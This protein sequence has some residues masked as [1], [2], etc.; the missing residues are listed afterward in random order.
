MKILITGG[1]GYIG[2]H[3][4]KSI[5]H[6]IPG[7]A[8]HIADNL[9]HGHLFLAKYGDEFTDI[10]IT[11][12]AKLSEYVGKLSPDI[13]VHAAALTSVAESQHRPADYYD[14][15]TLGTHNLA[16]ACAAS[17]SVRGFILLS[18][19]AASNPVSV[20]GKTKLLA[21]AIVDSVCGRHRI[22]HTSFRLYNACGAW[23][24]I[25]EA[26]HPETHLIPL[27]I[28]AAVTGE[29]LPIYGKGLSTPDGT[30][31]R[32]YIDVRDIGSACVQA[33]RR[34]NSGDGLA[35]VYDLG[36]GVGR[37][38]LDIIKLVER[39]VGNPIR[40]Q[41]TEHRAGDSGVLIASPWRTMR[42]LDWAPSRTIADSIS[43]ALDWY[44]ARG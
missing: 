40:T 37:S 20:Y 10:D 36:S 29:Q 2:S 38:V 22:G 11:D 14:T 9:C 8:V 27:A 39:V 41:I 4:A 19:C 16:S 18:T 28:H 25:G 21:E 1:A 12:R 33:I 24:D 13:V 5:H 15:N 6:Q 34:M 17:G 42:V 31:I 23:E 26:H 30:C 32:D 3:I 44:R 35:P 43:S 7:S